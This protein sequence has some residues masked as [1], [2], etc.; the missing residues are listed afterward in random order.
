MTNTTVT[1]ESRAQVDVVEQFQ[2]LDPGHFWQARHD[3]VDQGIARH[4]TFLITDVREV[5]GRIHTIV[6]HGHP[7][8]GYSL[9]AHAQSYLIDEFIANFEYDPDGEAKRESDIARILSDT[10]SMQQDLVE[11]QA[12]PQRLRLLVDERVRQRNDR[13]EE[14]QSN[15]RSQLPSTHLMDGGSLRTDI[16]FAI[17]KGI[18]VADTEAI[19]SIAE[20]EGEKAKAT[21]TIL[22]ERTAQIAA[23]IKELTPYYEEKTAVALAKAKRVTDYAAE[24]ASGVASMDLYTGKGVE[25]E[26]LVKGQ[27][28]P[29]D[30]KLTL[31][32]R[33]LFLDEEYAV[34]ADV[35]DTF[36]YRDT[37]KVDKAIA[38][39]P[40]FRDQLLP[41]ARC[42]VSVSTRRF[43]R[44]YEN[45]HEGVY[46]NKINRDA[47]LLVR[48]G[49]NVYRVFSAQ[50]SHESARRLFPTEA[51]YDG[52]FTGISGD[53]ITYN[54]IRYTDHRRKA[55]DTSLHYKR[56]LILLCGLDHRLGLFGQFYPAN[57]ATQFI[58]LSFQQTHMVFAHDDEPGTLI[59][60]QPIPSVDQFIAKHNE[61]LRSGS[62]VIAFYPD[63][64]T[65]ES[66][67]GMFSYR[68]Y[69]GHH[70]IADPIEIWGIH[71]VQR[72]GK[73]LVISVE[74]KRT[75]CFSQA[76]NIH[77][78]ATVTVGG[79]RG[80]QVRDG[81]LCLDTVD[82]D[83]LRR[84]IYERQHRVAYIRYIRL[85]K[86]ALAHL[87]KEKRQAAPVHEAVVQEVLSQG[88]VDNAG[89]AMASAKASL[90]S[91][92]A[93]RRGADIPSVDN[94]KAIAQLVQGVKTE[95]KK[96][97]ATVIPLI[98]EMVEKK[99]YR[100]LKLA[101]SGTGVLRLY[102]VP[103][104]P[105][106]AHRLQGFWVAL[107]TVKVGENTASLSD[108]KMT[109]MDKKP[110]PGETIVK[111]WPQW[112][113][114]AQEHTMTCDH[115]AWS[116]NE[117]RGERSAL[118]LTQAITAQGWDDV[119]LDQLIQQFDDLARPGNGYVADVHALLPVGT[120]WVNAE[121]V[122]IFLYFDA[123]N[124]LF[125]FASK[126]Q[127]H[128]LD[129]MIQDLYKHSDK[130]VRRMRDTPRP[131]IILCKKHEDTPVVL[132]SSSQLTYDRP[133]A[134]W[135]ATRKHPCF[136][137]ENTFQQGMESAM[138]ALKMWAEA[139]GQ[140]DQ[141][142]F[143]PEWWSGRESSPAI[144]PALKLRDWR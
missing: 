29:A 122:G 114:W 109:W 2:S 143:L 48:D 107:S 123:Q 61:P 99:G 30:Q 33:K 134:L 84:Y 4:D 54:D 115:S 27:S 144:H 43:D 106:P 6:L 120:A 136:N 49:E 124:F 116:S 78:T 63:L 82:P 35:D 38:E 36:D 121:Q 31:M 55:D 45:F 137:S 72:R 50:P 25:V 117:I 32:Q 87:E 135:A 41:T 97:E 60:H 113:S 39:H 118:S 18:T 125:H 108:Q 142:R 129:E 110:F 81:F 111:C 14:Q 21:A 3:I 53:K 100:P 119:L 94:K 10:Q 73:D 138:E 101:V 70:S 132:K 93:A 5:D 86:R 66:A 9:S 91:W 34:W 40:Q 11:L 131:N 85:F 102:H 56:F 76:K 90:M 57:E 64:I 19:R 75:E 37:D 130:W 8:K 96:W 17:G 128:L 23:K 65:H 46:H 139:L 88:I 28:A 140:D 7:G 95:N 42:V 141:I 47:Y 67:P 1:E 92:R 80:G 103:P 79:H 104:Q 22:R 133:E 13:P 16:G 12:D 89:D 126:L 68:N 51:E 127:R 98:E 20:L 44:Q 105:L 24:I 71:K 52:I 59:D 69:E 26:T 74:A 112:E 77:F 62:R 83:Q 15:T 58:R